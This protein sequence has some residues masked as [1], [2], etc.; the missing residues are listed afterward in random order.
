MNI[1]V[2]FL[3]IFALNCYAA[4]VY[5]ANT[6]NILPGTWNFISTYSNSS[7]PCCQ[8]TGTIIISSLPNSTA[9]II[10]TAGAWVGSDCGTRNSSYQDVIDV[11]STYSYNQ[12]VA[13]YGDGVVATVY[14]ADGNEVTF[15]MVFNNG[16]GHAV[17]GLIYNV[18]QPS[19][20][21]SG[22]VKSAGLISLTAAG[23]IALIGLIM[24]F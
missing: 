14:E 13:N 19:V 15:S 20:C 22:F 4:T 23:V 17:L 24:A 9:G 10:L 6:S 18:A 8:P 16:S 3:A 1:Q 2:F 7:S 5:T 21:Y 11:N 12:M